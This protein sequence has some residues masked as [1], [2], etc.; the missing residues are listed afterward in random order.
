[1][2]HKRLQGEGLLTCGDM[3]AT[4]KYRITMIIDIAGNQQITGR[5]NSSDVT[6]AIIAATVPACRLHLQTRDHYICH[7]FL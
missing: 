1:M 7:A 6:V 4:V 3:P 2:Q 5:L